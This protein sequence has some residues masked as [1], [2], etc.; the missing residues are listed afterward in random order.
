MIQC[1]FRW[2]YYISWIHHPALDSTH[3]VLSL[4]GFQHI[5]EEVEAKGKDQLMKS[6]SLFTQQRD[7]TIGYNYKAYLIEKKRILQCQKPTWLSFNFSLAPMVRN[8]PS[9]ACWAQPSVDSEGVPTSI[10]PQIPRLA[11][12]SQPQFG[13]QTATRLRKAEIAKRRWIHSRALYTPPT[14]LRELAMRRS[15]YPNRKEGDAQSKQGQ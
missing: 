12:A 2:T 3:S 5:N 11:R 7:A 14:T 9:P 8:A 10:L 15:R 4:G 13:L 6:V 1:K